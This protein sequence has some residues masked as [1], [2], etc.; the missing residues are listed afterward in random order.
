MKYAVCNELFENWAFGDACRKAAELGYTGVEIAPFTLAPTVR[1]LSDADR[2][3]ARAEAEAAGLEVV[4]LHW[5]FA[6][7]EGYSATSPDLTIRERTAE[8]LGDLA[9]ACID[10]GGKLLV[11]GSPP[12]RKM[13]PGAGRAEATANFVDTIRRTVPA[14]ERHGVLLL[15]EP[16]APTET[17]FLN[18][19]D[20]A[21]EILDAV[22]HPLVRLHL[23]CKAMSAESAPIPEVVRAHRKHMLHFHAN[24][25]N[26]R[27]PGM[28]DLEFAPILQT[29]K[30]LE[31]EGWI[32]VEVFDFAP[33]PVTIARE[34]IDYLIRT[35]GGLS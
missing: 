20:H 14:L 12:A 29:L 9:H 5:L 26:K 24:D 18:D 22:G 17:D 3:R 35:W 23:D 11:F 1:D 6:R 21:E 19:A 34:S 25:P 7:T 32:S 8:Y 10:L 33:D 13:P 2:R 27:G 4:G 30:D 28:G 16:L 15:L 31:Y